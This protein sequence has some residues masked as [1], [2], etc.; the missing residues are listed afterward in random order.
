MDLKMH[1]GKSVMAYRVKLYEPELQEG[2]CICHAQQSRLAHIHLG[3]GGAMQL[4]QNND[5]V[6]KRQRKADPER[7]NTS[8]YTKY[9]DTEF[10]ALYLVEDND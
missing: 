1:Q 3:D 2:I 4:V 8:V 7:T 5:W 9:T 6:V 10:R